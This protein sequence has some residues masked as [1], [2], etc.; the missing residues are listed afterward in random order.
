MEAILPAGMF[1]PLQPGDIQLFAPQI[2][3]YGMDTL[4]VQILGTSGWTDPAVVQEV[5]SRHTDGVVAATARLTQDETEAFRHF[6]E[7]YEAQFHKTLRN[8]V[9]A[10]GYDA[11][12]L[13]LEAL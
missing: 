9:P 2:T 10:Y 12:A 1:L 8:D 5:D 7:A 11:A 3:F 6:R 4:G 13:V